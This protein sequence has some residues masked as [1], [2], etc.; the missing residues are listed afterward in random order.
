MQFRSQGH[1]P[2]VGTLNNVYALIHLKNVL[3]LL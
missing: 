2:Q 3:L 1:K